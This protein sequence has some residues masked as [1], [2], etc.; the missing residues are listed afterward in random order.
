[1]PEKGVEDVVRAV[2]QNGNVFLVIAGDGPDRSRLE[3]IVEAGPTDRVRFVG[4][5]AEPMS[6]YCGVDVV[7]L[8]SRGG[9]SMPASLIEAGF[10]ALPAISTPVGSIEEIVVNDGTGV[11]VPASSV[12]HLAAAFEDLRLNPALRSRLGRDAAR[13]CADHFEIGVV[14]DR[15]LEVLAAARR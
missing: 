10:C 5:V 7:V 14:A 15:W 4:T 9:D 11:I 12:A 1:M 2:G 6:V 13:R 3:E 8:A